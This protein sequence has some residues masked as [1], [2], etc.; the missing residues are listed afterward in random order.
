MNVRKT[1]GT[2]FSLVVLIVGL[3]YL[4]PVIMNAL[5][6]EVAYTLVGRFHPQYEVGS[7]HVFIINA[8]IWIS[9]VAGIIDAILNN[10]IAFSLLSS[11]NIPLVMAIPAII[12]AVIPAANIY[13]FWGLFYV[14]VILGVY[15]TFRKVVKNNH[16]SAQKLI[17]FIKDIKMGGGMPSGHKSDH[18]I[19]FGVSALLIAVWAILILSALVFVIANWQAFV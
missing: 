19:V 4:F 2:T 10:R 17:P 11:L 13:M 18:Y 6:G 12:I 9:I 3:S 8:A 5:P 16:S 1:T 7:Y 14:I 15:W